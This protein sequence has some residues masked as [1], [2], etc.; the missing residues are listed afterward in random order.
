LNNIPSWWEFLLLSL[1]IFRL[2]RL[3]A[4][5]TILDRPRRYLLR[6]DPN[7]RQEGDEE[8][9]RYRAEWGYFITCPWCL[10]FG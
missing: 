4:E 6:L 7:W 2:Y 3:I 9:D 8:G 1:A 10:G 5:D